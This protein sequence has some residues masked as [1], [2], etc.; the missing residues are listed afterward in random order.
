MNFIKTAS[1]WF[2]PNTHITHV[3]ILQTKITSFFPDTLSS[4]TN[5]DFTPCLVLLTSSSCISSSMFLWFKG[6]KI[7]SSRLT[8]NF[9][10]FQ[11]PEPNFLILI[12]LI[13]ASKV[14]N[15]FD[16]MKF[17]CS[18]PTHSIA[19]SF[20]LRI[21]TGPFSSSKLTLKLISPTLLIEFKSVVAPGQYL[22]LVLCPSV[23]TPFTTRIF[24]VGWLF[25]FLLSKI[26]K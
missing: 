19:L 2:R 12:C 4:V 25:N 14:N 7:Y 24:T 20:F 17:S 10:N 3:V 1:G 16:Q 5:L 22:T 8:N 15:L 13:T 18:T 26:N 6:A 9:D 23:P 21:T 11:Y